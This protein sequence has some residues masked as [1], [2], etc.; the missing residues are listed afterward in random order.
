MP[1]VFRSPQA[2]L[3]LIEVA[4]VLHGGRDLNVLC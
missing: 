4:R 2:E 3:D 1:T